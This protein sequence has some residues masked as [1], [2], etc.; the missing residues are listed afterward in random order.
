MRAPSKLS[1][2]NHWYHIAAL[3]A[4]IVTPL[5]T[6][7]QT[8]VNRGFALNADG[9]FKFFSDGGSVRIIGWDRDSVAVTGTIAGSGKD[10]GGGNRTGVKFGIESANGKSTADLVVHVPA[11]ARVW[12]K[13]ASADIDVSTLAGAVDISTVAGTVHLQGRPTE[14]RAETMNGNLDI[15]AS[16]AYTRLKTATGDI[17]WNGSSDDVGIITVSGRVLINAGTVQR[18]RFESIDGEIH[19]IGGV[20]K[21]ASVSVDTHSGNVVLAFHRGTN[22]ELEVNAPSVDLLGVKEGSARTGK[23]PVPQKTFYRDIGKAQLAGAVFTVRSYKG[24]VSA[25]LQ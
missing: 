1:K 9:A 20:T 25:V 14:V 12:V 4:L 23:T 21:N 18:A 8:R 6:H 7:A 19:Y 11:R 15:T 5:A 13:T 2:R 22:V 24:F 3:L 17:T 16:A 10:F